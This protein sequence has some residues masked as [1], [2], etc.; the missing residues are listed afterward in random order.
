[1]SN[2]TRIKD[3][4]RVLIEYSADP[5]WDYSTGYPSGEESVW[6]W[7]AEYNPT[8]HTFNGETVG[9][10][11]FSRI[12]VGALGTWSYPQPISGQSVSK[13][14]FV[15]KED[16]GNALSYNV[17][18]T[19]EDG[20]TY[21]SATPIEV[22]KGEAGKDA[23]GAGNTPAETWFNTETDMKAYTSYQDGVRYGI[24]ANESVYIY[25]A[26]STVGIKP[27]N[28]STA[29]G[30]YVFDYSF[31]GQFA[32]TGDMSTNPMV[33]AAKA[34]TPYLLQ[35]WWNLR[36]VA[37]G[38]EVNVNADWS[39]TSGDSE[40]LNKPTDVTDLSTHSVT[41]L[42]DVNALAA[43]QIVETDG[44]SHLISVAKNTAYNKAFGT[45]SGT[46]AE[47]DSIHWNSV[48]E[49]VF[50][51]AGVNQRLVPRPPARPSQADRRPQDQA[52]DRRPTHDRGRRR[53]RVLPP[54]A[55]ARGGRVPGQPGPGGG[56]PGRGAGIRRA[57]L[58]GLRGATKNADFVDRWTPIGPATSAGGPARS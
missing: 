42:N 34:V 11:K 38:A 17:V 41:E 44:S 20:T 33:Q 50:G 9:P 36:N 18:T 8:E 7:E 5:N 55:P 10:H 43:S 31:S 48:D 45:T 51:A 21:T 52:E 22:Q 27:D 23:D 13:V 46:V 24:F 3:D 58:A 32:S 40:I 35:Y 37:D 19:Y 6:K 2:G 29:V 49:T 39:S 4:N 28:N 12:K 47:G 57:E 53:D 25:R 56:R 26:S 54:P 30:R 14:D 15:Y 1:M 16:L